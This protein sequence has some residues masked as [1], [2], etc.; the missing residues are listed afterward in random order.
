M[1]TYAIAAL[2]ALATAAACS[3]A[4]DPTEIAKTELSGAEI[5]PAAAPARAN[6]ES[7]PATLPARL[8]CLR[9]SGGV[10]VVGHR[11]GPT[12]DFPE[13]AIETLDRSRAAGALG[14]EIDIAQSRDGVLFLMHDDDL[15]RTSTGAGPVSE[16]SWAE[17]EAL[18]LETYS[19]E[20][21][22]HPPTLD[23]ALQ[24]VVRNNAFLELDKKRST[25]FDGIID[26]I[27]ANK[28]GDNVV[29][30]TYTD[31]QALEVHKRS[32]DLI[33]TATIRSID[34]FDDLVKRG[35][36]PARTIA[37]TG[38]EKPDP[39]LWKAL[40]ARGVES[41]F[42]TLGKRG[43]RLDDVYWE[44]RDGSEY[45]T[46]AEGGLS[47]VVSDMSDRVSRELSDLQQKAAVCGL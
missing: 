37:W 30:I 12:R 17:I 13:N 29:L 26:A 19:G 11:G 34:Q 47:L 33:V 7:A 36:D 46:L 16:M 2:A 14:M 41:A 44:D 45:R 4:E 3:R 40:A 38:T 5:Q 15:D 24:W 9:Q 43:E 20:T 39:E 25:S 35:L 10:V 28:A 42:G 6:P 32:K 8:D 22:Y 31:E 27:E 21:P 1:K 18:N 23:A